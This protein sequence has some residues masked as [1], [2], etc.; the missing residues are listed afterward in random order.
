MAV[1]EQ[2]LKTNAAFTRSDVLEKKTGSLDLK[3]KAGM[4]L[5]SLTV[6]CLD[7]IQ[8]MATLSNSR[9]IESLLKR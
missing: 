3:K 4:L 1:S 9:S 2:L 6:I 5:R 8:A 7:L